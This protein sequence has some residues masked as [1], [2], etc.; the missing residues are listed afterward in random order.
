M[1]KDP[2]KGNG[3]AVASI[4]DLLRDDQLGRYAAPLPCD[5]ILVVGVLPPLH[6]RD[7]GSLR[8]FRFLQILVD[9][10]YAVT[11]ASSIFNYDQ[12]RYYAD[13]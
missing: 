2:V 6:D 11:F 8:L 10:G 9:D 3:W 7:S 12:P 1:P 5:S 13:L 4:D